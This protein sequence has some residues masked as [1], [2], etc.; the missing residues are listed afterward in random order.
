MANLEEI[1]TANNGFG[2]D[3]FKKIALENSGDNLFL[4]PFSISVALA[5]TQLGARGTTASQMSSALQWPHG[6]DEVIHQ[7]YQTYLTALQQPCDMYKLSTANR[8]YIEKKYPVL[9]E[10]LEKTKSFYLAEPVSANFSGNPESEREQINAWVLEQT[11]EKIKDL[12]PSG[13]LDALTRMV[14][15][16]AI[17]FKGKWDKEFDPRSTQQL[18]FKISASL[19]AKDVP[20]MYLK[21][22]FSFVEDEQLSCKAIEI[23]YKGKDLSMVVILPDEDFGLE[24]LIKKLSSDQL[25]RLLQSLGQGRQQDVKLTLPK[26]EMTSSQALKTHLSTLG[27]SEAFDG[28][29]ADFSGMTKGDVKDLF[30]SEVFHKAFIKV[31]EEGTEA[32][33]ATGAVMMMR[34]MPRP[35]PEMRVDHPFLLII[36]DCRANGNV[37]FL[38]TVADPR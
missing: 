37:L 6:K 29:R 32:A 33:A 5:M 11:Q 25:T 18:P 2:I 19:G 16:N 31:N 35:C 13:S 36:A 12:L 28:S 10:F 1:S 8:I 22:K 24:G 20:M 3:L 34:S 15:V 26:F 27:M 30:I 4:S 7:G 9:G 17:Y 23:P 21:S 38:G 14:L